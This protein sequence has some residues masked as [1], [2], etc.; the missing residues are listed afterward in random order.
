MFMEQFFKLYQGGYMCK[1]NRLILMIALSLFLLN[2]SLYSQ[3]KENGAIV[4]QVLTPDGAALPGV[5]VS[6]SSPALIGG[7]QTAITD[8]D[9]RF[10]F[11]ALPPGAYALEAMASRYHGKKASASRS[12]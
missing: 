2:P 8:I 12:T 5:S 11:I 1:T 9:G 3:S 10:R 7:V 6:I 4:G